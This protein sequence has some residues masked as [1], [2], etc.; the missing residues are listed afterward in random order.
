VPPVI[1]IY[2]SPM[3][4]RIRKVPPTHQLEAFDLRPFQLQERRVYDLGARLSEVLVVW[5]TRNTRCD[6]TSATETT[7]TGGASRS[8]G[9]LDERARVT[10]GDE[11]LWPS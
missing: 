6:T 4:V 11:D 3:R 1:A 5:A 9:G 8:S 2:S 10:T 7:T